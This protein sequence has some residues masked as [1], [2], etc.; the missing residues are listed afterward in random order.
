[1]KRMNR[2]EKETCA[3]CAASARIVRGDYKF[4]ESGLSNVTLK[5]I[6]LIRC[7]ECGNEDPLIPHANELMDLL[8]VAVILKPHRLIG[9]EVRFLRKHA[10]KTL[11][12]F[13]KWIKVDKT[14]LSR[15]ENDQQSIGEQS[16][17]LIRLVAIQLG[18]EPLRKRV[19]LVVQRLLNTSDKIRKVLIRVDAE[20]MSYEYAA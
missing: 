14:T 8:A 3:N 5:G 15:W 20:K 16:D 17:Q 9:E 6:E 2:R 4:N 18:D 12:E 7:E 10:E 11:E 1:M 19:H 13:A